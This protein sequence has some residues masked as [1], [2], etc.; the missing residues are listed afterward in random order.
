MQISAQETAA[1]CKT[2]DEMALL[3]A[4]LPAVQPSP[5]LCDN[6]AAMIL[7]KDGNGGKKVKHIIAVH[8]FA[9]GHVASGELK[10]WYAQRE[11]SVSGRLT[12][13][14]PRGQFESNL[15]GL[16]MLCAWLNPIP[17]AETWRVSARVGC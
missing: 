13:A 1:W 3:S 15:G 5:V 17:S 10:F 16:A 7:C 11:I 2:L 12:E 14:L 4:D 6:E 8:H 9:L